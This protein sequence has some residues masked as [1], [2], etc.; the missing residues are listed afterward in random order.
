MTAAGEVDLA[1]AAVA[2][3]EEALEEDPAVVGA[4]GVPEEEDL[5]A[6][7]AEEA[8]EE[9][10]V[11]VGEAEEDLTEAGEEVDPILGEEGAGVEIPGVQVKKGE[12]EVVGDGELQPVDPKLGEP[13]NITI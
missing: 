7:G 9:D 8:P 6:V 4:E 2:G 11:V 5:A 13:N 10:L 1:A 3:E 12:V